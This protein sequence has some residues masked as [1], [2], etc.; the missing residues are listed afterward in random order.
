MALEVCRQGRRKLG[1]NLTERIDPR[2]VPYYWI[3]PTRDEAPNQ[4]GTDIAAVN[5]GKVAI[6]PVFLDLTNV[7]ALGALAKLANH[8]YGPLLLGIVSAGLIVFGA[9][10]LSDARYRRI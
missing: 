8:S 1:D 2:G 3:G 6:T 4:P 5:G 10:S 9:Y 7:P